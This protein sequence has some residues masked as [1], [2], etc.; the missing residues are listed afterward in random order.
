MQTTTTAAQLDR[1]A[2]VGPQTSRCAIHYTNGPWYLVGEGRHSRAY[3]TVCHEWLRG[4]AS[5]FDPLNVADAE[6]YMTSPTTVAALKRIATEGAKTR[7]KFGPL[8]C[9][10]V[11]VGS[12]ECAYGW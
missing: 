10:R 8:G 6:A 12:A 2:E 7:I 1:R 3:C 4:V 9:R 11:V 5:E